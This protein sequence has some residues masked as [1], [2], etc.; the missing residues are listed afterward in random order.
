MPDRMAALLCGFMRKIPSY[1]SGFREEIFYR[2]DFVYLYDELFTPEK[3]SSRSWD[4]AWP[5]YPD[6]LSC[7]SW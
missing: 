6:P 1:R 7:L 5:G 2:V 4:P 3:M